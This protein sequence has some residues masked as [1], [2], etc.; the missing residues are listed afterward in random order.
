MYAFCTPRQPAY[1]VSDALAG[2]LGCSADKMLT[3]CTPFVHRANPL[4]AYLPH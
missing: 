2:F 4:T 3:L 1:G